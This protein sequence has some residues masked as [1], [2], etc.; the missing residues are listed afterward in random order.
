MRLRIHHQICSSSLVAD[1]ASKV[2][3]VASILWF[4]FH[5]CPDPPEW[6]GIQEMLKDSSWT[7][8]GLAGLATKNKDEQANDNGHD[9]S[10]PYR[11][12]RIKQSS[13]SS[14]WYNY[15]FGLKAEKPTGSRYDCGGNLRVK[16]CGLSW[17][18]AVA[19][20]ACQIPHWPNS[21]LV[22]GC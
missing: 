17:V 19:T 11:A 8:E 7:Q 5:Q 10:E 6:A 15:Y 22:G 12:N 1:L 21:R 9:M 4:A 16:H 3:A 2:H 18:A 14:G 13:E 20:A